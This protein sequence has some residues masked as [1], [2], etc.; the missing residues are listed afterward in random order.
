MAKVQQP[1]LAK[2]IRNTQDVRNFVYQARISEQ[3]RSGKPSYDKQYNDWLFYNVPNN[4]GAYG[5]YSGISPC[6]RGN[7]AMSSY[8]YR[9]SV[10]PNCVGYACG[11]FS[12]IICKVRN[13]TTPTIYYSFNM[14]AGEFWRYAVTPNFNLSRGQTPA[15]G[16]I[17]C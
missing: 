16:S 4:H 1:E 17:M 5:D 11:R 15:L 9:L 3:G 10:L 6:I 13:V 14:N 7:T 12:E 2:D 8:D